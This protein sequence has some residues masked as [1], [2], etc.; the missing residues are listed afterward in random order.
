MI[1]ISLQK[2][3]RQAQSEEHH[4]KTKTDGVMQLQSRDASKHN[5]KWERFFPDLLKNVALLTLIL[6]LLASR[7]VS[8]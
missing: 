4:V 1:G 2:G 6:A 3:R 8:E 5:M 7:I